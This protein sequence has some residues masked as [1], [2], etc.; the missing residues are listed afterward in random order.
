LESTWLE[1]EM[2]APAEFRW[3]TQPV[4]VGVRRLVQED[5]PDHEISMA[6]PCCGAMMDWSGDLGGFDE[7]CACL[8]F[9]VLYCPVCCDYM[10]VPVNPD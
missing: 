1:V 7:D 2:N 10:G 3:E 9:V 5:C 6:C 8:D 4:D